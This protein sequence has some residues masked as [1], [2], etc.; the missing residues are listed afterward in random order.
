MASTER[1][2]RAP[3]LAPDSL[4]KAGAAAD[5]AAE[6]P[7]AP[8]IRALTVADLPGALSLSASAHWNQNEADWCTM[9]RLGQG[10]GIQAR[11]ADGSATLAASTLS[12]IHI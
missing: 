11:G 2:P 1:G 10:W 12:L 4:A 5:T 3:A 7:A 8:P 9:L 6:S